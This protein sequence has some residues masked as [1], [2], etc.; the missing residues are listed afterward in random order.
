MIFNCI[1]SGAVGIVLSVSTITD[2]KNLNIL[3]QSATSPERISLIAVDLIERFTDSNTAPLKFDMNQW[4]AINK[5]GYIISV[6]MF[7]AL[8]LTND[9]LIDDLKKVIMDV[10]LS[11]SMMFLLVPSSRF[12]T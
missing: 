5:N 1:E 3:K 6:V 8:I 9:I 4:Q 12:K 10:L 11:I 7:S 2:D